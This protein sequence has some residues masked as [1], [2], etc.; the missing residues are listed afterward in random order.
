MAV[1][2]S[3]E[4]FLK[5]DDLIMPRGRMGLPEDIGRLGRFWLHRMPTESSG[6][7]FVGGGLR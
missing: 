2:R 6:E 5:N 1:H 4:G 3:D 7:R